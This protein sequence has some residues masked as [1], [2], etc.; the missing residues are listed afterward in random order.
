MRRAALLLLLLGGAGCAGAPIREAYISMEGSGDFQ[1]KSRRVLAQLR[2]TKTGGLLLSEL[3]RAGGKV[4]MRRYRSIFGG[5]SAKQ[6]PWGTTI[7]WDPDYELEGFPAVAYLHHE[8]VH[9]LH[10]ALGTYKRGLEEERR[11]IG[12]GPHA[13]SPVSENALRRELG[14]R[15]REKYDSRI[16][17]IK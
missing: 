13:S 1:R 5:A 2:A 8:L 14:I 17:Y 3:G 12:L 4:V 7:F 11:A 15:L 10:M 6:E 16:D 9:A